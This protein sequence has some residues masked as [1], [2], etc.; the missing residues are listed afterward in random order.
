MSWLAPAC[1]EGCWGV[2]SYRGY[3]SIAYLAPH[4]EYSA[5]G[6]RGQQVQEFK[7]FPTV[8]SEWND[9]YRDTVRS[10]W[11]GD[12]HSLG[13]FARRL[14]GSAD[15]YQTKG[16]RPWASVNFVTAHDG[17]TLADLVSYNQKHNQANG[18]D[19][20]DGENHNRS[21]NC[22]TE[23]PTDDPAILELRSRQRRNFL[24]TLILSQGIPMLLAGDE[25]G[26]TQGGN[27][28]AYCQDNELSWIAWEGMDGPMVVF[29]NRLI[30]IRRHHPVFHRR[31]FFQGRPLHGLGVSDI[32][33]LRPDG[34]EMSDKD[35]QTLTVTSVGVFLNGEA[36]E[37][38]GPRGERVVDE[39][40]LA[41]FNAHH[42]SM[43]FSLPDSRFGER[44]VRMVDTADSLS[45]G[46]SA[47]AG[48]DVVAE[49]RSIVLMR[50]VG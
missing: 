27:N 30:Q 35:W 21:W 15:L 20:R 29:A 22:G 32:A 31:R 36:I 12:S 6:Q 48:D 1:G 45:E 25:M 17:F 44:W 43:T 4:N 49:S 11:R 2:G 37:A 13:D 50:R 23:G 5:G 18:E 34:T 26:R 9:K 47:K 38:P 42:E 28:N 3:N 16:R 14:T 10:Y 19:N 24:V 8:R 41:L 40:F 46:D 7:H 33:W 39:S